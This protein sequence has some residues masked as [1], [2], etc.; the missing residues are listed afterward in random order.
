MPPLAI[1]KPTPSNRCQQNQPH[2]WPWN[3][4]T[5]SSGKGSG[6]LSTSTIPAAVLSA[7]SSIG[8]TIT[9]VSAASQTL[10]TNTVNKNNK[11]KRQSSDK[12]LATTNK[13]SRS[14]SMEKNQAI[15]QQ[16]TPPVNQTVMK[17]PT[18]P[19]IVKNNQ[20]T[21]DANA[22]ITGYFKTQTKSSTLKKDLSNLVMQSTS[23]S[24]TSTLP[25]PPLT[26]ISRP[27]SSE[28]LKK[29]FN[30]LAQQASEKSLQ[31]G[32]PKDFEVRPVTTTSTN[33]MIP[34]T[35]AATT[36]A[37]V[38]KV[39]RKTAK[40]S[41]MVSNVKKTQKLAHITPKKPVNIAPRIAKP[42][43]VPTITAKKLPDGGKFLEQ[44]KQ[45][46]PAPTVVLTA[47][48][49]PQ[50][51]PQ[52]MPPLQPATT[53]SPKTQQAKVGTVFSMMPNLVQIPNL[54][55]TAKTPGLVMNNGLA[56]ARINAAAQ[57]LVNGAVIKLQ[58]LAQN[59]NGVT[60][61]TTLQASTVP[62]TTPTMTAAA[63]TSNT[64]QTKPGL[65][66]PQL[67]TYA[68]AAAQLGPQLFIPSSAGYY[69]NATL[70]AYAYSGMQNIPALQP[71]Q[72]QSANVLPSI[73]T[74]LPS[75]HQT[76][77]LS[78]ASLHQPMQQ[79]TLPIYSNASQ[80]TTTVVSHIPQ[81]QQ[82]G[83]PQK[84]CKV[85]KQ[86]V[87]TPSI[88]VST[89]PVPTSHTATVGSQTN[90][91]FIKQQTQTSP[92]TLKPLLSTEP[93]KL[94][95]VSLKINTAL[96]TVP[97]PT[98]QQNDKTSIIDLC[99]PTVPPLSP[100]QQVL[101]R[102][103]SP[104]S[105]V[106]ERIKLKKPP[107]MINDSTTQES[108]IS[109]DISIEETP[110]KLAEATLNQTPSLPERSKSPILTQPKTIRFPVNLHAMRI[111]V[112]GMRRSDGRSD[113]VCYWDECTAKFDGN[114]QLLDHLQTQHVN[115]QT[116]PFACL[117]TGCKV[118]GRKSCSRTWL[119]RHV[120]PHGGKRTYKCIVD[121]CGQRFPSQVR[122]IDHLRIVILD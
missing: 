29:Y 53:Q 66:K 38:K 68:T 75:H 67:P 121:G 51:Q 118:Y 91:S 20:L 56:A 88:T 52:Q 27:K 103:V 76:V 12:A 42:A 108:E 109:I 105:L 50:T 96:P 70:P 37:A 39:E 90:T 94:V 11:L 54:V 64:H 19:L 3:N 34:T 17:K 21:E 79:K 57:L 86:V 83:Q 104:K 116:G 26:E 95:P 25:I 120:L 41:P 30:L 1:T 85:P 6:I 58:Q 4:S 69:Y 33:L 82:Q 61:D 62:F 115:P 55:S 110:T 32:A 35:I 87:P 49:I 73:N 7:A 107:E 65:Q 119:E 23:P 101:P 22:K 81:Q 71:I 59:G 2:Q 111:G 24:V 114:S 43:P 98:P 112:K 113:G 74:I 89:I 106:L 77:P 28:S 80:Q 47:I 31:K 46:P 99:S 18:T 15:A 48:R 10:T 117:W 13:K 102:P 36:I 16:S 100:K 45:L 40:V 60:T 5:T 122:Q 9:A 14:T 72:P 8:A 97:V 92:P 93:P 84:A 63:S 44:M 78:Q